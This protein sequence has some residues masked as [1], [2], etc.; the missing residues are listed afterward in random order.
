MIKVGEAFKDDC[1]RSI[2]LGIYRCEE[3]KCLENTQALV[4]IMFEAN[5][6]INGNYYSPDHREDVSEEDAC[7]SGI[8]KEIDVEPAYNYIDEQLYI[9]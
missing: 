6:V 4:D 7:I 1:L 8:I 5:I 2:I 3:L 9:P